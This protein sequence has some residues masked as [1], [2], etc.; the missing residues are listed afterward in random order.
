MPQVNYK[1]VN[2]TATHLLTYSFFFHWLKKSSFL[3]ADMLLTL[4]RSLL[5][6]RLKQKGLIFLNMSP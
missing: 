1:S 2:Y 5:R 6:V 4:F 3:T